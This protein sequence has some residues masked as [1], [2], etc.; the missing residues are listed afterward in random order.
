MRYS[1]LAALFIWYVAAQQQQGQKQALKRV[2][3]CD[4]SR[5]IF[6]AQN[7][8]GINSQDLSIT[9][10]M[11]VDRP[12][13]SQTFNISDL[14]SLR[15]RGTTQMN[16]KYNYELLGQPLN[17]NVVYFDEPCGVASTG[18]VIFDVSET[19]EFRNLGD[20]NVQEQLDRM[21]ELLQ[22]MSTTVTLDS[23]GQLD[24]SYTLERPI[25]YELVLSAG[26]ADASGDL[27]VCCEMMPVFP[28]IPDTY[29]VVVEANILNRG[30]SFI[31]HEYYSYELDKVRVDTSSFGSD[32]V[33]IADYDM[34]LDHMVQL[35]NET[36]PDGVCF[37]EDFDAFQSNLTR[38]ASGHVVNSMQFLLFTNSSNVRFVEMSPPAV[39]RGVPCE[40]WEYSFE[41]DGTGPFGLNG[42]YIV[43]MYFAHSFW[44]VARNHE[45]RQLMRIKLL[46]ENY[47]TGDPVDHLY[48]YVD[49]KPFILPY[50]SFDPC[51]ILPLGEN[52]CSGDRVGSM[53]GGTCECAP[54]S[55]NPPVVGDDDDDDDGCDSKGGMYA[56]FMVLGIV[57]GIIVGIFIWIAKTLFEYRYSLVRIEY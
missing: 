32:M 25:P 5:E 43:S 30:Y 1:L 36:Y 28:T 55:V 23:S 29:S 2:L 22:N 47:G 42:S 13:F 17:A 6:V 34:G 35:P 14:E 40:T 51:S 41:A 33:V 56:L 19:G 44:R 18:K 53:E 48:E 38:E 4:P 9:I 3:G 11:H 49:F 8:Q 20:E 54:C 21:V 50:I 45:Y 24:T 52:C 57:I 31:Q 7:D 37:D 16:V 46:G 10:D 12:D 15:P 27:M 26:L 39:V